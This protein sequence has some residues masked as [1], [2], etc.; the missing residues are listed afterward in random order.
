MFVVFLVVLR[1]GNN[2]YNL[3][4]LITK[5]LYRT[6]GMFLDTYNLC[7]TVRKLTENCRGVQFIFAEK[8]VKLNL[9]SFAGQLLEIISFK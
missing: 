2:F 1:T 3:N 5:F 9:S 7:H 4:Y 6:C 8:S